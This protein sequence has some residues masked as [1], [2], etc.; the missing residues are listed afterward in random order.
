MAKKMIEC[1]LAVGGECTDVNGFDA[2]F[3]GG[4]PPQWSDQP[5]TEEIGYTLNAL[6]PVPA[7]VEQRGYDSAG[8]L[9]CSEYWGSAGDLTRLTV[10]RGFQERVYRFFTPE[11]A[12]DGAIEYVSVRWPQA[13]FLLAYIDKDKTLMDLGPCLH[14]HKLRNGQGMNSRTPRYKSL[15]KTLRDM[16]IVLPPK[17]PAEKKGVKV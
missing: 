12:P 6:W 16:G 9:W 2:I 13:V 10:R 3:R 8:H 7:A 1:V 4:T 11:A 15:V 5:D 14:I 17:A